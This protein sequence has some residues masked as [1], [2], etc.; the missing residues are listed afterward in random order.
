QAAQPANATA[1]GSSIIEGFYAGDTIAIPPIVNQAIREALQIAELTFTI[2]GVSLEYGVGIAMG[3]FYKTP[4]AMQR[5][6]KGE[7]EALA[8]LIRKEKEGE[9]VKD[10]DD[11]EAVIG[12]RY[13]DLAKKN[14]AHFAPSNPALV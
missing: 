13:L 14:V 2:N 1:K 7:L 8:R 5:A 12:S 3:D 9:K 11:W 6:P 4:E 10:R